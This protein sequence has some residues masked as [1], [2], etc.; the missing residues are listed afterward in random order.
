MIE[1]IPKCNW[2]KNREKVESSKT[3]WFKHKGQKHFVALW[4]CE[5]CNAVVGVRTYG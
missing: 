4:I 5:K 2:C 3:I 1:I